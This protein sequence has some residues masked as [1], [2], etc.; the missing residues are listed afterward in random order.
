MRACGRV[1]GQMAGADVCGRGSAL[2]HRWVHVAVVG[3]YGRVWG[4]CGK[5]WG[6]VAE[7]VT[8]CG[9]L[10][11][12]VRPI[13][14]TGTCGRGGPCGMM[15]GHVAGCRAMWQGVGS[16]GRGWRH[17]TRDRSIWQGMGWAGFGGMWQVMVVCGRVWAHVAG[18]GGRG[19]RHV[20]RVGGI[21]QGHMSNVKKSKMFTM[22][23]VHKNFNLTQ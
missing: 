1:W 4:A 9:G 2:W 17:I 12:G 22:N 19:W 7:L 14:W 21:W 23:E 5:V 10:W 8:G 16:C 18:C 6:H 3:T 15:W 13:A 11:Y 20:T